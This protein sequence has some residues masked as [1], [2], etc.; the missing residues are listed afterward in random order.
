MTIFFTFHFQNFLLK[1]FLKFDRALITILI[2]LEITLLI[3]FN[4]LRLFVCY[5]RIYFYFPLLSIL[6]AQSNQLAFTN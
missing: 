4:N 5:L 2:K 6:T 3:N 1:S